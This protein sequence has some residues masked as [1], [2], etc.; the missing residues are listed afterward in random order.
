MT[1]KRRTAQLEREIKEALARPKNT[2]SERLTI[3]HRRIPP[4]H[5]RIALRN[6]ARA[7]DGET[8]PWRPG[9]PLAGGTVY[10]DG[11]LWIVASK[12]GEGPSMRVNLTGEGHGA[13]TTATRD[14]LRPITW[15][16]HDEDQLGS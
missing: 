15:T 6:A 12:A 8:F 3:N 4:E 10:H 11:K 2:G 5:L 13:M 16:Q 1:T 14:E 9:Y 7:P